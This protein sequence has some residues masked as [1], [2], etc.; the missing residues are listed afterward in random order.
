MTSWNISSLSKVW[1]LNV[2]WRH[3][4]ICTSFCVQNDLILDAVSPGSELVWLK[5]T[6]HVWQPLPIIY[7]WVRTGEFSLCL[8]MCFQ[9]S[10]DVQYKNESI[11]HSPQL[12]PVNVEEWWLYYE[13]LQDVWAPHLWLWYSFVC[14]ISPFC[15]CLVI[16]HMVCVP[17]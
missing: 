3:Y 15:P 16:L 9:W 8:Y 5:Q 13:A 11:Y 1:V 10:S 17:H 12:D 2:S 14:N 4:S 6:D 7:K